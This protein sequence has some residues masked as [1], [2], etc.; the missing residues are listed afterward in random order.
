M[1]VHGTEAGH[2]VTGHG[3]LGLLR[4]LREGVGLGQVELRK[5]TTHHCFKKAVGEGPLELFLKGFVVL[6]LWRQ[7]EPDRRRK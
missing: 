1:G 7:M 4:G 3:D 5:E 2:H 6:D